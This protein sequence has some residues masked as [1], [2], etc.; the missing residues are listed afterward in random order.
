MRNTGYRLF[1]K[2]RTGQRSTVGSG[3]FLRSMMATAIVS[4]LARCVTFNAS[5]Y[6]MKL[7]GSNPILR[8]WLACLKMSSMVNFENE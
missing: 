7:Q 8:L 6:A 3:V 1:D 4:P 5:R 2:L